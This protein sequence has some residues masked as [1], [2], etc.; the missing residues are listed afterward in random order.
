MKKEY[1]IVGDNNFWYAQ[2]FTIKEGK[3]RLKEIAKKIKKGDR[4][5]LADDENLPEPET[6]YLYVGEEAG[7]IDL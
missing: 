5:D 4:Y 7:R 2:G 3:A 6:L 1:V